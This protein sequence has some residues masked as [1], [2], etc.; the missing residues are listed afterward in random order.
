[1]KILLLT[2]RMTA[3]G[4]ETHIALLAKGLLEMGEEVALLSAG[5]ALADR[6]EHEGVPQ[7]RMPLSTHH[8]IRLLILR[9]R[10]RRLIR[11]EGFDILHAHARI[12]AFLIRGCE[13]WGAHAVVSVHACF[14][15]N[16]LL[17]RLCYWGE[18]TVAVSEDLRAYVTQHY[19]IPA[20][21]VHVIPN[22]IDC[23]HFSPVTSEPQARAPRILFVSRLDR[24]CSLGAEL[25][26]RIA[27][28]LCLRY[29]GVR[30]TVAGG[31]NALPRIRMLAEEVNVQ[32]SR[33]AVTLTGWVE[34]MPTLLREHDIFVGVSRAAME[35]CATGLPVI[36]CGNE[37][38]FG[39]LSKQ[40]AHDAA[41]TNFCGRG[42]PLPDEERLRSDLSSLLESPAERIRLGMECRAL[43]REEFGAFGMCQKTQALYRNLLPSHKHFTLTVGCYFGCGNPGDDAILLGLV[44]QLQKRAPDVRIIALTGSPRQAQSSFGIECINRKNP[45][46]ILFALLCSDAFLFGGGSLLQNITSNRSLRYYLHLLD[47]SVHLKLPVLFAGAGIGPLIGKSA[48]IRVRNAL[49]RC[50]YISLRDPDSAR[51]LLALGVEAARLHESADPAFLLPLPPVG[52][53]GYLLQSARFPAGKRPIC[54]VLH[55]RI[56]YSKKDNDLLYHTLSAAVRMLCTRHRLFP[57]FLIFDP[58]QDALATHRMQ[59]MLGGCAVSLREPS[60][61]S[62]LLSVCEVLISMRLHAMILA[63]AVGTPSVG[64][65]ADPRDEK[66]AS[67]AKAS[68]A[69]HIPQHQ[70]TAPLLVELVEKILA[71]PGAS[72]RVLLDS[73]VEMRK[74]AAKDLENI[75]EMIYNSKQKQD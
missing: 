51:L 38:Y 71:D 49:N 65:P 61:A 15:T 7:Y 63:C 58:H 62:A 40:R 29:P 13:K 30:I 64:I 33:D 16:F 39:V 31:G 12:P 60:D 50:R 21:R 73:A 6:L 36:L 25:L 23:Q 47:L 24:D 17:S 56:L 18:A 19:P 42:C 26:C 45:F 5:G 20:R 32:L 68:G 44:S 22:G 72:Q 8:P 11:R 9:H 41:L 46:S 34:D 74:K 70:L 54:I 14:R 4:A 1:M 37:G 75:V 52:R 55:G 27:P 43:I 35:A 2:D 57:L 66:I 59:H 28:T 69:E 53:A 67:F 3:G 10:I 48:C